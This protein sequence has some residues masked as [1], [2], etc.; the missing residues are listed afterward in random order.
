MQSP[1]LTP[2]SSTSAR[3]PATSS[4]SNTTSSANTANNSVSFPF[5]SS[6]NTLRSASVSAQSLSSS[7]IHANPSPSSLVRETSPL[8][9]FSHQPSS[10]AAPH[11]DKK[12]STSS[13]RSSAPMTGLPPRVTP[14]KRPAPNSG[15]GGSANLDAK[16]RHLPRHMPEAPPPLKPP[17]AAIPSRR[18]SFS[19]SL[20]PFL[21]I[22]GPKPDDTGLSVTP[23]ETGAAKALIEMEKVRQSIDMGCLAKS[24]SSSA[25]SVAVDD[26]SP[27]P[28]DGNHDLPHIKREPSPRTETTVVV[29]RIKV[30]ASSDP[31]APTY[32][33]E[34]PEPTLSESKSQ[35][36]V[37]ALPSKS[38]S[39]A[40]Y[41]TVQ[42]PS[43]LPPTSIEDGPSE[44][45][46][47]GPSVWTDPLRVIETILV[48]R[49]RKP[50]GVVL[51]AWC[52]IQATRT[53]NQTDQPDLDRLL[54][55]LL[56]SYVDP[57]FISV[58]RSADVAS[59]L[60]ATTSILV[61]HYLRLRRSPA[62]K[63]TPWTLNIP[64]SYPV[65]EFELCKTDSK[66]LALDSVL[67]EICNTLAAMKQVKADDPKS[68]EWENAWAV[69]AAL[70]CFSPADIKSLELDTPE[71]SPGLTLDASFSSTDR[72]FAIVEVLTHRK[73]PFAAALR[74]S[75]AASTDLY[76][77]VR[78]KALPFSYFRNP[79]LPAR[80]RQ[81]LCLWFDQMLNR[82]SVHI[83]VS[84]TNYPPDRETLKSKE[85]KS[86]TLNKADA[87][88]VLAVSEICNKAAMVGRREGPLLKKVSLII[89]QSGKADGGGIGM[90]PTKS[91]SA[92]NGALGGTNTASATSNESI[93]STEDGRS[94]AR[95]T[96]AWEAQSGSRG[97]MANSSAVALAGKT[98]ASTSS[99]TKRSSID[100]TTTCNIGPPPPQAVQKQKATVQADGVRN[101]GVTAGLPSSRVY[102][103]PR[104]RLFIVQHLG[105]G[106]AL[107]FP[108]LAGPT[109]GVRTAPDGA[110]LT[111]PGSGAGLA[112]KDVRTRLEAAEWREN[113]IK[114]LIG[115][116][117]RVRAAMLLEQAAKAAAAPTPTQPPPARGEAVGAGG[118]G[119]VGGV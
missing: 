79:F 67:A 34:P 3:P 82:L 48:N 2:P 17:P 78:L 54:T 9:H 47:N 49:I 55:T 116:A 38:A 92:R 29:D 39:A 105:R 86:A 45:A 96:T 73:P 24:T 53:T 26:P 21:G 107:A 93:V 28:Q 61:C 42:P 15:P 97:S 106:S 117:A 41:H 84:S 113:V 30:E 77:L 119:G 32:G 80:I 52:E 112:N 69:M 23:L 16:R 88:L 31:V 19:T 6:P 89:R 59:R 36:G 70:Q 58:L 95:D 87:E 90:P 65:S 118:G 68:E 62:S 35:P 102:P 51:A 18:T 11:L 109:R 46:R 98:A 114:A 12:I 60:T 13:V 111:T 94:A 66:T 99:A 8:R 75:C 81:R 56:E 20:P 104:R 5:A 7:N 71:T 33:P 37:G 63:Q 72:A 10:S 115:A 74:R 50:V 64:S 100:S 83:S 85:E 1:S 101:G 44:V 110:L 76:Q 22:R 4:K 103:T 43:P 25:Q 27:P 40:A 57:S 14:A 91:R 108:A